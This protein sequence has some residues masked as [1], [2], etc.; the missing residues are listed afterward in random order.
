MGVHSESEMIKD[1]FIDLADGTVMS[2]GFILAFIQQD[3]VPRLVIFALTAAY[4]VL[5]LMAWYWR[6]KGNKQDYI[7]KRDGKDRTDS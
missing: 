6:M 2:V 4:L 1:A 5:R 3:T 7:N